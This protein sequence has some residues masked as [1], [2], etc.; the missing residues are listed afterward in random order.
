MGEHGRWV[1]KELWCSALKEG[2]KISHRETAEKGQ[3]VY[4]DEHDGVTTYFLFCFLF[5][6]CGGTSS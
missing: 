2:W 5:S 6:M 1:S 3:G 4:D